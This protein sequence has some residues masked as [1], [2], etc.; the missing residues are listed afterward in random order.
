MF[1]AFRSIYIFE[2]TNDLF[3]NTFTLAF[4]FK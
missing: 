4:D 3:M 2:C 1:K